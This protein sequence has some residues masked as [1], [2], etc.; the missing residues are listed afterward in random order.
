MAKVTRFEDLICWRKAK[1]LV[2]E[3]YDLT[4]VEPFSRD[5]A[6]KNQIRRAAVSTMTNIAEGFARYHKKDF[7]RFLDISQSS[8]SEVKSLLYIAYDQGYATSEQIKKIQALVEETRIVILGLLKYIKSS[9]EHKTNMIRESAPEYKVKT[10][11]R[12]MDLPQEFINT[13]TP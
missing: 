5:F 7:I 11:L 1:S 9:L 2:N 10:A 3:I 12:A 13:L 4:K 8:A 6:L